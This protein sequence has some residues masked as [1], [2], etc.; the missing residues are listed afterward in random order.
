MV[1]PIIIVAAH[2][3]EIEWVDQGQPIEPDAEDKREQR[4][5]REIAVQEASKIDDRLLRSEYAGEEHNG[6]DRG[7]PREYKNAVVV[8]PVVAWPVL[9]N[10]F[11]RAEETCHGEEADPIE[12]LEE[13]QVRLV[14]IDQ[15]Q[16]SDRHADPGHDVDEEQPVP[17]QGIRQIA[18]NGRPDGR[19]ERGNE[20]DQRGDH[21]DPRSRKYNEGSREHGRDHAAADE[22]L[23]GPPHDHLADAR[24]GP[25]Q[26]ARHGEPC[27]RDREHEPGAERPRQI[28]GQ[29]NHHDFG[30]QIR[31]LYPRDLV[32]ARRKSGLDFGQRRRDDLDV[33]NCHEHP[34]HHGQERQQAT[35]LDAIRIGWRGCNRPRR[36]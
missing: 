5:Q 14:E 16:R 21:P 12:P 24:C 11:E 8:E 1:S 30:D 19:C 17:R 23:N 3:T 15:R 35:R 20:T 28:A 33:E 34:E 7:N 22:A 6:R 36:E 32:G 9:E 2:A 29:G 10:V 26:K 13:R 31:G 4:S 27:G 25:A 18:A